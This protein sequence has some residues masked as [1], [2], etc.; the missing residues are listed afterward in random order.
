MTNQQIKP[1]RPRNAAATQE[2]ILQAATHEFSSK[3]YD[4][5]RIDAI[6]QACDISKN[7]LYHY[8]QGKEELFIRVMERAYGDMREMQTG[9]EV[10]GNDPVADMQDLIKKT[11]QYFIDKPE[12]I[13]LLAT[14]N[15]HRAEHIK[16]SK[17]IPELFNP[18]RSGLNHILE[19]GKEQGLFRQD[20]DW[21]ELY[22]SLSG[23]CSYY[24]SNR[25]TLSFVLD[26]DLSAPERSERRIQHIVDM[27]LSYL[28]TTAT[29][30]GEPT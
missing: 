25:Y 5:A 23:L 13:Q 24:L 2:R 20:A 17:V 4:G 19:K 27:V 21:V 9:L 1:V 11:A 30:S 16:K 12:F 3:G 18:L 10:V 8:Y 22:V 6:V 29:A 26:V 28:C 14:E 7:L 15:L